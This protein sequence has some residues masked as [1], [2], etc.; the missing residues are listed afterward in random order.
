MYF[1]HTTFSFSVA[2]ASTTGRAWF[3]SNAAHARLLDRLTLVCDHYRGMYIKFAHTPS[4]K[5]VFQFRGG[6][7]M[8]S[9]R[10]YRHMEELEDVIEAKCKLIGDARLDAEG[11]VQV[12]G[13]LG[14]VLCSGE[15][16]EDVSPR[17][18]VCCCAVA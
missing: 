14:G 1:H 16:R 15:E 5:T 11:Y 4:G 17:R 3:Q 9:C 2:A 13:L 10:L 18:A 6:W 12:C 7:D 8:E